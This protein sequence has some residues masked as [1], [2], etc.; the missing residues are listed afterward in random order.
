MAGNPIFH[1][2]IARI[3]ELQKSVMEFIPVL[4]KMREQVQE[5]AKANLEHAK[6]MSTDKDSIIGLAKATDDLKLQHVQITKAITDSKKAS[7]MLTDAERAAMELE[8]QRS[9]EKAKY[10]SDLAK[11]ETKQRDIIRTSE[12]EAKSIDELSKKTLA[13]IA[14]RKQMTEITGNNKNAFEN[15]SKEISKNQVILKA[16]DA[17]IGNHH[18]NVGNYVDT[19]NIASM[20]LGEMKKAFTE[21]ENTSFAGKSQEEIDALKQKIGDLKDAMRDMQAEMK[22]MGTENAAVLVSGLKFISAGVEGV[23]GSLSLFGVKSD[24][25]Q[26]LEK[27]MTSLIAVTQALSVIEDM[28]TSGT[29]KAIAVRIQ[30]MALDVKDTVVKWGNAIATEAQGKAEISRATMTGTATVA[31]KLAAAAQWVWNAALAANP[32]GLVI[33]AV[34]ALAGG[35]AYLAKKMYDHN[36][37]GEKTKKLVVE[38]AE[39]QRGY[40]KAISDSSKAY[41]E[42]LYNLRNYSEQEKAVHKENADYYMALEAMS[43]A[44]T[45]KMQKL[46]SIETLDPDARNKLLEQSTKLHNLNIENLT[47]QHFQVVGLINKKF[48]DE[49]KDG[50]NKGVKDN[51][52]AL[53]QKAADWNSYIEEMKG[54]AA[55]QKAISEG[56]FTGPLA[57]FGQMSNAEKI[58][59][60]KSKT[61]TVSGSENKIPENIPESAPSSAPKL[62]I[63]NGKDKWKEELDK[64]KEFTSEAQNILGALSDWYKQDAQNQVD[65]VNE[66]YTTDLSLLD[67]QL[68][69]KQI[70][71]EKYNKEKVKLEAKR[72]QDELKIQ[73]EAA[74][75]QRTIQLIQSVINTALGVTGALA[76][77]ATLTPIGAII[78][79]ALIGVAGAVE[80]ASIASQKF[81]QG[82]HGLLLDRSKGGV[83]KGRSHSRGGISLGDIGE[84]E[85]GEYFGIVN[86]TATEK[87]KN[88]LPILFDAINQG[89][90]ENMF[91][92]QGSNVVVNVNDKY[93]KEMLAEMKNAKSQTVTIDMGDYVL[94]QTGN[95]TFKARKS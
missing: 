44:F 53:R 10:L 22:V 75:K 11:Q 86:R 7:D 89:K 48:L 74:E 33:V 62:D 81:A 15:L 73:K 67:R 83:L 4:I 51:K 36:T 66:K 5:S 55:I 46:R 68:A 87:Y 38:I 79:A 12:A 31:T 95:Y 84:A 1:E 70:S 57:T 56:T 52:D 30:S 85:G 27:K 72:K 93:G 20:S 50:L 16:Y 88:T 92:R 76:S 9:K 47:N 40:N 69:G 24:V 26:S 82:G 90:F 41:S 18:R 3:K 35:I 61:G 21:L 80:I 59:P 32:I 28:V 45:I 64:I 42:K 39:A 14:V 34:A 37:V 54:Y 29:V 65:A 2:D 63:G 23:V 77:A 94:Y 60:I 91:A 17:Q 49:E 19:V 8:K 6:S 25:I 13:M 71:E 78:M 43:T 58:T